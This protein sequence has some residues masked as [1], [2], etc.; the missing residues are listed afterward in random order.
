VVDGFVM[1]FFL[2]ASHADLIEG[3]RQCLRRYVE[4]VGW[5]SMPFYVTDNGD[6]DPVDESVLKHLVERGFHV[7]GEDGVGSIT[8][9]GS[10]TGVSACEFHYY[11]RAL[12][13]DG[14]P[15]YRNLLYCRL[16]RSLVLEAGFEAIKALM[17]D[18]AAVLPISFAYANP[19]LLYNHDIGEATSLAMKHLGFDVLLLGSVTME[20]GNRP[21]G[22]YWLSLCG[23][24][25]TQA[26]GGLPRIRATLPAVIEVEEPLAGR[27]LIRLGPEPE[28]GDVNRRTEF[29]LHRELAKLLA[30]VL[31]VPVRTYFADRHNES[32]REAMLRWHGRFL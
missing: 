13:V 11:G 26:L 8:L 20:L 21:A 31:H 29:P 7:P 1:A 3:V 9:L 12:P 22:V 28:V 30:P 4:F 25:L 18:M 24:E 19:A 5:R 23:A 17:V 6:I 27:A 10:D 32:D 14:W 16:P 2:N 15:D